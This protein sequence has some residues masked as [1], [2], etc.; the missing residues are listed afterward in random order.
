MLLSTFRLRAILERAQGWQWQEPKFKRR[1]AE[2]ARAKCH[3]AQYDQ[4]HMVE[5][6]EMC[7]CFSA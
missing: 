5:T 1:G 4:T 2:L 3:D 7:R 6:V